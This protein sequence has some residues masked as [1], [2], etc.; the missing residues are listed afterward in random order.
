M[1]KKE[2]D[3]Y[4][5]ESQESSAVEMRQVPTGWQCSVCKY[6]FPKKASLVRH[7]RT[8]TIPTLRGPLLQY[9]DM[10]ETLNRCPSAEHFYKTGGMARN[11]D[12]FKFP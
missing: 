9:A 3:E 1:T 2:K 4:R 11:P 12:E 7:I 5:G 8:A 6:I 10:R